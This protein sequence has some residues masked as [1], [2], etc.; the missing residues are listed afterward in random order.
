M[1]DD[2]TKDQQSIGLQYQ[3]IKSEEINPYQIER[4]LISRLINHSRGKRSVRSLCKQ[5]LSLLNEHPFLKNQFA[6]VW[7]YD[8]NNL[9]VVATS[10]L[11]F[12]INQEII[13]SIKQLKSSDVYQI[14]EFSRN[15]YAPEYLKIRVDIIL[16][17]SRNHLYGISFW[18][19]SDNT[20]FYRLKS[21]FN[22]FF[23]VFNLSL[24]KITGTNQEKILNTILE[25]AGD[26]VEITN[27]E[28]VIQYVNPAFEKITQY[29]AAE[30]INKTVSSL[31]RSPKEDVQL[32]EH[33]KEQLEAGVTWRGQLQSRKKDGSC[34]IA[35]ATIV[36]VVDEDSGKVS[37]HVAIKQDITEHVNQFNQ[38]KISEERYRNLMNAAS[39][40]IFVHDLQGLFLETNDAACKAL[41]Y[42]RDEICSSYVWDIEVGASQEA[43][44]Q[45]WID[46]QKGPLRIE[47]VHKRKD[48][49]T[50][51]VDVRLGIFSTTGENLVLAIVRDITVQKNSEDTIRKLTSALEQSP[52]LVFITDKSGIIEYVNTKVIEQTGYSSEEILGQHSRILQ[53][54]KTQEETY[55]LM[56]ETLIKGSEWRGE[57]LNRNKK[58][59][60][61]WVSA[62][63]SPIRNEVE[64]ITHYLAVMEDVS[65]KKS[66][67]E[68]LKHQATYDSL[69][70]LP[71][72][73]YGFNKL[74]HAISRAHAGA[75]KV[76]VLFLDLD[77]FKQINDSLGHAAGDLLLK[78]LSERYLSVIRQTDTIARLGGDEFMM[79]LENLSHDT[80]AERIAKKCLETCFKPFI[81]ESQELL[82]SSSIGIAIFPDHGKDAKTLM[83]NAD[84]AMYQSKLR[85]KN[86]W[87]VF[88]STMAEVAS[89]RLRI[90]T[91]LHQGILSDELYICYQPI[92]QL[93]DNRVIAVE[94]L[95][96]W[97][98]NT[99]GD[100]A[101]DQIIPV[102]EET[103]MIIPLGYWIL[104]KVCKQVK[105]WQNTTDNDIKVAINISILQLKQ[106]DFIEQV[107][108]I[109][110]KIGLS[111][112]SLIFEITESAFIDDSKFILSQLNQL[113]DMNIHC[114]LDDFGMGYSSLSYIRTYP[115]KSLKI[116][117][118][119][120]QGINTNSND[121]SLV[122]SIIAMSR[123]LKLTVIAEGIETKEQLELMRSMKCDLAQGW[124]FSKALSNDQLLRFLLDH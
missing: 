122:S 27:E 88:L 30:A 96:R 67:E 22:D 23:G 66:Y 100:V 78:A 104:E 19:E 116:D 75:R 62:I 24:L 68:M 52:V 54:D 3:L 74:E 9:N 70:N 97:R 12:D 10:R 36:P 4:D 65:Q 59:D 90:K 57:L 50:F 95:L 33:I 108:V 42:T 41:G 98:S 34:W 84:T 40:A 123:N 124:Y 11:N 47:G 32:F 94:A 110:N 76:A 18:V 49:T 8:E 61:F 46:L 82:I 2:K 16:E 91:E 17:Q 107:K 117:R 64:E 113:N 93:K 77:E 1:M 121:L 39:D 58:G 118:V 13:A 120:M 48:G 80:D 25:K 114:S 109:L 103:G 55:K 101:P 89:N 111:A 31:L 87:T 14:N 63:I 106:K 81:I 85:G 72:R 5:I 21:F 99:L 115:F 102:A 119:F 15:K 51:P 29:G 71:N 112:E 43:L 20:V 83:R 26:S 35:Q 79:I 60:E 86:N 105:E 45:M 69:T 53:S 73:F 28:A 44:N 7:Y 92:I 38:L 37:H 6:A 56:W